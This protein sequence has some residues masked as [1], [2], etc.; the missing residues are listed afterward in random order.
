[1]SNARCWRRRLVVLAIATSSLSGCATVG[2]E[3][4]IATACPPVVE[5]TRELQA[6]A[7]DELDLLPEGSA[8]AEMLADYSVMRDQARACRPHTGDIADS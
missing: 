4:G 7:A 3:P 8:I 6:R 2:S 5:Y 1:M